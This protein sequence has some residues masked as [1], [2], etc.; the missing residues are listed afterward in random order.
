M[1]GAVMQFLRGLEQRWS[2]EAMPPPDYEDNVMFWVGTSLSIAG[3]K[4]LI[5]EGELEE[6]IET[7]AITPIPGTRDWV[8]G[9]ASHRGSLLPIISGD[10]LFRGV[11]YQGRQRDHCIVLKR[12]GF[13]FGITLSAIERD[14]KFPIQNRVMD[15]DVDPDFKPYCLGGFDHQGDFLAVLDIDRLVA[16]EELADA[17]DP[18]LEMTEEFNH[19]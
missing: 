9:V 7:P 6:V 4:L 10:V 3:V 18:R 16:A 5:G 15:A 14:L 2:R 19:E 12:P 1:A 11:P 13:Y 17:C 8:M